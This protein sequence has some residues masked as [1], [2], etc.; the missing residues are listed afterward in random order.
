[1]E[2]GIPNTAFGSVDGVPPRGEEKTRMKKR[3]LRERSS[4][5]KG[6]FSTILIGISVIK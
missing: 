5:S 2:G 6:S 4:G 1:M 3:W